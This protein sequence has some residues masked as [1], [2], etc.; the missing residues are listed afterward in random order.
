MLLPRP[1]RRWLSVADPTTAIA[2]VAAAVLLAVGG[3]QILQAHDHALAD[4]E[5]RVVTLGRALAEHAERSIEAVDLTLLDT[6][7][8][9]ESG[10]D[11]DGLAASLRG[12]KSILAQARNVVVIGADGTWIA[13]GLSPH[14]SMN[15]ADR[16]YFQWHRDHADRGLHVGDPIIGRTSG[17]TGLPLSRRIDKPD[18][19]FGGVVV[20]TLAPEYFEGFYETV[21][22]GDQGTVAM[23][24]S[25]GRPLFRF[26]ALAEGAPN[27]VSA[28]AASAYAAGSA[29]SLSLSPFDGV[30]RRTVFARVEGSPLVVS[31]SISTADALANWSRSAG[32]EAG[33]LAAAAIALV[34]V[35][36]GLGSHRRRLALL[37]DQSRVADERYRLVAENASDLITLRPAK[38]GPRSYV[39]P[40]SR[41]MVGWEPDELAVMAVQDFVHPEDLPGLAACFGSLTPDAPRTT[42]RHRI[43]HKA[44]GYVRIEAILTLTREGNILI[45]ARDVSARHVA[46]QGLAESEARFRSLADA[47]SDMIQQLDLSGRRLYLSPASLEIFGRTPGDMLGTHPVDFIMDKDATRVGALIAEVAEGRRDQARSIHQIRHADGHGVFVEAQFRLVRERETGRPLEIVS[48]VRDIT[49]RETL[50]RQHAEANR[51]LRLAEEIAHVGHWRVDLPATVTWSEETYRLHGLDPAT[52][53]P[54][55][56]HAIALYH[57]DDRAEVERC[58]AAAIESRQPYEFSLRI[59][60]PNGE[61]RDVVSR[62]LCEVDA[63]GEV[64]AVFGTIMDVTD[65]RRAE[66]AAVASEARYRLLADHATDMIT[67]MD[68]TGRR[69]FVTPGSRDLLGYEPEELVGTN[70]LGMIHPDDAARLREVLAD[71]TTGRRDRAINVN[72]L[73]HK[74]GHWVWVEASLR[75]LRDD[76]GRAIGFVAAIRNV[77]ERRLAQEALQVS[78]ARYRI[79]AEATTDVITQ[80]GTS[81]QRQYVS[82]SCRQ[83]LGFEPEELI[84][85]RPST[86]IHPDEADAVRTLGGKLFAGE[87]EGDRVVTT[88]RTLHKRGHWVWV[89]AGMNL[90]RDPATGAPVSLICSLRDVT[91]RQEATQAT[92]RARAAAERANR[93]KSDFVA[94]MSHELR[95]PLTGMLGINDLLRRDPSLGATQKRLVDLASDAGRSLLAIV[96]DVLDFSKI[97]AGQLTIESV[98]FDLVDLVTSC[99]DL[100]QGGLAGKPVEIRTR[101]HDGVPH[102]LVGD[103]TRLRQ[104]LLNLMTNAVKFTPSGQVE[105]GVAYDVGRGW[106]RVDVVDT[107]IGIPAERVDALFD[108]FTQAD[109]SMTRRYGGTGL[110]LAICRRLVELMGGRI[111]AESRTQ[112]GAHFWFELPAGVHEGVLRPEV[113]ALPDRSPGRVHHVLLAEDNPISA[114]IIAMM[115]DAR[116]FAV[117]VV[118]DGAAAVSAV[119][120]DVRFSVALMDLQ[121]P[122]MDGLSATAEIRRRE[123]GASGSRLPIVGLT[124]NAAADDAARCLAAGMTAHVA[125]PIVWSQL[126][127]TIDCLLEEGTL[128]IPASVDGEDDRLGPDLDMATLETLAAF[129]GRDKLAGYLDRFTAE[130]AARLDVMAEADPEELSRQAHMLTSSA[131]QLGFLRLSKLAGAISREAL[132]G[133]PAVLLRDLR[134]A[135]ERASSAAVTARHASSGSEGVEA[136]RCEPLRNG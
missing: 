48:S 38:S 22:T 50:Q 45:A 115:L 44:G 47:S 127:E 12:R 2:F 92:E 97:E 112:G 77:T 85:L 134:I 20:V 125:K 122:V 9:V 98:P 88:Y 106:L 41:T 132:D 33:V 109:T 111:G 79:L 42:S 130:L 128:S 78:E 83:V 64:T 13:D 6:V 23:W 26:P 61:T 4:A 60:R 104:V 18:G 5:R 91:E 76:E 35:G 121:M 52:Y 110:G 59:L 89:E 49:E 99:R 107:G 119:A 123:T 51:W 29:S 129:V 75:Q 3:W 102:W 43:R 8:Q 135:A 63:D 124:A 37:Q 116:G 19:A 90:V 53:R 74:D 103:P 69:L 32:L 71:L 81:M 15:S 62:G 30:E 1:A 70:P 126:W 95:T 36:L 58:V 82:P 100:T 7:E 96:N 72:R 10:R 28:T 66:R 113:V 80:I 67:H 86:S 114:E 54:T 21:A 131:G 108:R 118:A 117:T 16:S 39:S 56:E 68:L 73:Q 105:V 24:T 11:A 101:L 120:G 65:L 133:S 46:E 34:L 136:D 93:I 27:F 57:P 14:T 84:G 55:V 87:V 40:S 17:R 31:A 94:N 25:D